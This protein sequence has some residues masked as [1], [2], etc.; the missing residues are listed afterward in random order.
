MESQK[1]NRH[2][3]NYWETQITSWRKSG[4]TQSEY[5]L[6]KN[7]NHRSL[8]NWNKKLK[9]SGREDAEQTFVEIKSF[10]RFS[11]NDGQKIEMMIGDIRITMREGIDPLL[12]R[13][14]ALALGGK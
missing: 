8:S 7:L 4:L 14:I 11:E 10:E 6:Q 9:Q 12:M 13:D 5:C 3:R 2:D 1:F